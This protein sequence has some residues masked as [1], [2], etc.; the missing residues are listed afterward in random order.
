MAPGQILH[1]MTFGAGRMPSYAA[2]IPLDQR[3][4]IVHYVATLQRGGA[5]LP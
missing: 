2:Q 4:L 1:V 5:A 3:W